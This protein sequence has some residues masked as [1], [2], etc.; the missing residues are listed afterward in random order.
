MRDTKLLKE[1]FKFKK[2]KLGEVDNAAFACDFDDSEWRTVSVPHDWGIEG[3]FSPE[4]DPSF[5]KIE[6]D[7]MTKSIPHTGR[8]GGL[9]TVGEGVYRT[10]ID[11]DK[12]ETAFLE[13]D[14]VMWESHVYV[15]GKAVGG[16]HFR[17][18]TEHGAYF[19]TEKV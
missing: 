12:V 16:C 9:P 18:R 11:L 10:W 3:D 8:T 17:L 7:G 5:R 1:N 15:N 13:L 19:S 14:G 6:Q 2:Y 4:N